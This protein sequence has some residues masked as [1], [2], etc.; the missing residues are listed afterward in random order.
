MMKR[1]LLLASLFM[2]FLN[3]SAQ[4]TYTVNGESLELSMEVEGDLDLLLLKLDKGY[5]FFVKDSTEQVQELINTRDIDGT[6]FS[7]YRHT[8]ETLTAGSGMTTELVAFSKY[9]LKEFIKAYNRK[10]HR[11]YAYTSDKV[12]TQT[13]MGVFGGLTNHPLIENTNNDKTGLFGL[14]FELLEKK[15]SPRQSGFMSIEHTLKQNDFDYVSTIIAIGHRYR[16]INRSKFNIYTNLQ[17]ATYT[18]SKETSAMNTE[19]MTVKNNTLRVPFIL[20]IGSDIKVS[21]NSYITFI[22][23]EIVS[24]FVKNN[25]H[26]PLNFSM[27]Y[28]FNL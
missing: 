21:E 22:Y 17:I 5:R 25:G 3:T 10:G 4:Q 11:R 7:E 23:N 13:R 16:F 24:V 1:F 12:K 14:E 19:D 26:F 28:K 6:H 15:E 20:G 27:G 18:F 9:G 8:L 2:Y